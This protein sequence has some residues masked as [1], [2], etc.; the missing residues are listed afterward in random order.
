M[1]REELEDLNGNLIAL[2]K[3]I[4]NQIDETLETLIDDEDESDDLGEF[5]DDDSDED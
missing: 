2:L 3:S 5:D 4:R 1:T